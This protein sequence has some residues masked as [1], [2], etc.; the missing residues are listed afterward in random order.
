MNLLDTL[1]PKRERPLVI[2]GPCS[3]ESLEQMMATAKDLNHERVDYFRAGIWKPRTRPG[4]FEGNGAKALPWLAEVKKEYGLKTC[5]EVAK[6]EHVE[7]A[8]E[9]GVDLL[10][11]GART[12]TNPFAVQEVAEA[13]GGTDKE[14]LVKNPINPDVNLW[15][16]AIERLQLKGITKIGAI[17]RGFSKYE[18]SKFRNEPLWQL[19]IELKRLNP[20]IPMICDPSHITGNRDM[21]YKVSQIALDLNFDGLMIESHPDP[22]NAWSDSAQQVTPEQYNQIIHEL[23]LSYV[24]PAEN[25]AAA[26]TE[27]RNEIDDLDNQLLETLKARLGVVHKIANYKKENKMTILQQDRWQ[28]ILEKSREKAANLSID[29]DFIE[30]IFK[31]IHQNSILE[32]EKIIRNK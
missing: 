5:T 27:Y 6:A 30:S 15:L 13:L 7:A 18:K 8:L 24:N 9:A 1:N 11:V 31:S 4:S 29:E 14:V 28:K 12:T 32:Q 20:E 25:S 17:H 3:A 10:W 26:L 16:G 2:A 19:P 23:E 21:I 22:A